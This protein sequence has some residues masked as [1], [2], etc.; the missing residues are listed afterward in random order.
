[1]DAPLDAPPPP[2]TRSEPLEKEEENGGPTLGGSLLER[3]GQ[4]PPVV[5][6]RR[7]LCG[8]N[9]PAYTCCYSSSSSSSSSSPRRSCWSERLAACQ[10]I[11]E[12]ESV[13]EEAVSSGGGAGAGAGAGGAVDNNDRH[14]RSDQEDA[15]ETNGQRGSSGSNDVQAG[16][17]V[18]QSDHNNDNEEEEV[19]ETYDT[20]DSSE[21]DLVEGR[22]PSTSSLPPIYYPSRYE[23]AWLSCNRPPR[24][25][26]KQQQQQQQQRPPSSPS[27]TPPSTTS[28]TTVSILGL[29]EEEQEEADQSDQRQP[30][31]AAAAAAVVPPRP[32]VVHHWRSTAEAE[33]EADK[34]ADA[35][36]VPK[37]PASSSSSSFCTCSPHPRHDWS[38]NRPIYRPPDLNRVDDSGKGRTNSTTPWVVHVVDLQEA[39]Q[40][41]V[42]K[43]QPAEGAAPRE[44]E[45]YPAHAY[46]LLSS[47]LS[48]VN[49]H[50]PWTSGGSSITTTTS[51]HPSPASSKKKQEKEDANLSSD[52]DAV[53]LFLP[54]AAPLAD[55]LL[56]FRV[57][58]ACPA[59]Y[60]HAV[61]TMAAATSTNAAAS[62][63]GGSSL[64]PTSHAPIRC[65]AYRR[66]PPRVA[67]SSVHWDTPHALPPNPFCLWERHFPSPTLEDVNDNDSDNDPSSCPPLPTTK[68][69]AI[70]CIGPPFVDA[71]TEFPQLQGILDNLDNVRRDAASIAHWTAWPEEQHYSAGPTTGDSSLYGT[72][73]PWTVF[74]LCHCFPADD[75]TKLAWI[76][77]T[78]SHV[79]TTVRLLQQCLGQQLRTALFSRLAPGATL[80]AHTGWQDL[81]NHVLRLHIPLIVPPSTEF[82]N[83]LD[84]ERG[85]ARLDPASTGT[86]SL[87]GLWVD[88]CVEPLHYG[89]IVC[90]DDSKLHWAFNYH[91]HQE[92][93]VLLIDLARPSHLPR[94][95]ATGG[96]TE[97]LD[98]F[99]QQY[100]DGSR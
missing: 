67:L 3:G 74:P 50:S 32:L 6:S 48:P 35:T 65:Y 30:P 39:P 14:D 93:I 31:G 54:H 78:A 18:D 16:L 76:G 94:G 87:C 44:E 77:R 84:D 55:V 37:V 70:R 13:L 7:S 52:A 28:P 83:G 5:Q 22:R 19:E 12:L 11:L 46:H 47:L 38:R 73:V 56:Q 17:C 72:V 90:F 97:E 100:D 61:V 64:T 92:R 91:P 57:S 29:L 9:R 88:G 71:L 25:S 95:T 40:F 85:I 1:M 68:P 96:H 26:T 63:I 20:D 42:P 36:A 45:A 62:G 21:S 66:L 69:Y 34:P 2:P 41:I 4:R 60:L 75:P 98:S 82:D 23:F 51:T 79:P 15:T 43:K 8:W 27:P 58:D 33:A 10:S 81:A 53:L 89:E 80:Q 59:W 86:S 99:I 49:T 24:K